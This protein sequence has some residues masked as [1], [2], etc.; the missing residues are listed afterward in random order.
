MNRYRKHILIGVFAAMA[1]WL[2]GEWLLETVLYEPLAQRRERNERLSRELFDLRRSREK[3]RKAEKEL[4]LFKLQ[5]LPSNLEKARSQYQAW[6]LAL[7][8]HVAF[9]NSNVD[10]GEPV[11][12]K[13]F[14]TLSYS[15]RGTGT[16]EQLTRFLYEFYSTDYLHQIRSLSITPLQGSNQLEL[17]INIDALALPEAASRDRLVLRRSNRL[18]SAQ[19][20]DY[21]WVVQRNL[22]GLRSASDPMNFTYLTAVNFVDG[23]PEAWFSMRSTDEILH[24]RPGDVIEVG[25]FKGTVEEIT[26]ADV[27]LESDGDRW[28][29]TVGENLSQ[30]SALP[31]EY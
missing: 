19:L 13:R 7:V 20:E 25:Q 11:K 15:L 30:A 31:A 9:T 16:L 18:A 24:L 3:A 23:V 5:S 27:V 12:R 4:E 2:G 26:D 28:L 21:Q 8:E 22:F 14:H 29:L 10:L 1:L 17:S 6:L